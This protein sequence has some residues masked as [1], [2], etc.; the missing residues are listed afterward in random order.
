MG[1]GDWLTVE[2]FAE[3]TGSAVSTIRNMCKQKKLPSRKFGVR[4]KINLVEFNR[5]MEIEMLPKEEVPVVAEEPIIATNVVRKV[6]TSSVG[7]EYMREKRAML[8]A[9][10][11]VAK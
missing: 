10:I 2:Q 5:R 6:R 1:K 9:R 7:N 3:W 8:L 11:G 4:W